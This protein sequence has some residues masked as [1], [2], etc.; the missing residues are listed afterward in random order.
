MR[1]FTLIRNELMDPDEDPEILGRSVEMDETY[2][3]GKPR[4]SGRA[5]W[6]KEPTSTHSNAGRWVGTRQEGPSPVPY[7]ACDRRPRRHRSLVPFGLDLL[8]TTLNGNIY[9]RL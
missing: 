5:R 4:A 6:E 8:Y 7:A 1:I 2:W 3:G 9:D